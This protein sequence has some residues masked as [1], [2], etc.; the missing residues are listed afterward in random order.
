MSTTGKEYRLAIRIAGIIDK[1]FTT[2]LATAKST[3]SSFAATVSAMDKDFTKLDRGYN[4]IMSA[5]RTCF[6]AIGTAATVAAAAVGTVTVAAIK[7]GSEF[8]AQM[9]TVQAISGASN[10]E[11]EL[12]TQ[13]ARELGQSSVF[14]AT[15][16]GNAMEYMGMAGWKTEQILTGI[17]GVLNL[18]AASGEDFGMVSDIVT[19]DLTAFNMTAD[20]TARMV[21]VMAQAAMNSNT[22]VAKMGDTFKYA[23]SVA[24]AMGYTI[25]DIA[26]ATGLMA[27]SGVKSGMAGTALRNII[28][29]MAKPTK[30]SKE[31]MD[32]LGLSLTDSAGNM[33]SFYDIMVK[34]RK[35]MSGMT[36]T[37][38]AYYGAELG[39]MR[40]MTG[41]L[42]IANAT[43][44]EFQ[45]LTEA[46]Y[47][48][49]GAAERMAEIRL[50]NLSGDVQIMK[51]AFADAGMEIYYQFNDKLRGAVQ[52]VTELTN[53]AKEGIPKM[54]RTVGTEFPTL[55]R[56]FNK[57]AKP[58]FGGIVDA[59]KWLIKNGNGIVS[60]FVGIGTALAAYKIASTTVHVLHSLMSLASLNPATMAVLGLVAAIGALAGAYAAYKQHERDLID[61]SLADHFGNVALSMEELRQVAEFL[62]SSNSLTGAKK[63]LEEFGKLDGFIEE[64]NEAVSEIDKMNW[65]VSIGMKLSEDEN[66]AYKQAISDYVSEAQEYALQSQYA[67]S[68]NLQLAFGDGDGQ[69]V[70]DK[71]NEFY[72]ERYDTLA[73][74]GKQLNSAVTDAFNDGLLEID[75]ADKIASI[76]RQMAEV[77]RSLATGELDAKL[78][79]LAM[80]NAGG[81]ALS[82]EAFQNLQEGLNNYVA[83]AEKIYGESYTKNLAALNATREGGALTGDEYQ[84]ALDELKA[85]YL[86]DVGA[87]QAKAAN[88]QLQTIMNQYA[89]ELGPAIQAYREKAQGILEQYAEGGEENWMAVY[90]DN[91]V[92]DLAGGDLDDTTKGAISQLL[93]AAKPSMEQLQEIRKGYEELGQEIPEAI[94]DG[95][96]TWNLLDA[97]VNYKQ[98]G[99]FGGI[100]A[101]DSAGAVLGSEIAN[102]GLYDEFYKS[103]IENAPDALPENIADGISNAAAALAASK[104]TEAAEASVRPAVEGMYAW[105]QDAINEYYAK[106]FEATASV[107]VTLNPTLKAG[108]STFGNLTLPGWTASGNLNGIKHNAMGGIVQNETLSWLAENGPEAVIP[109][110]GSRRAMSLWER[111]GQ[112]L[113]MDSSLDGLD[114]DGGSSY[115]IEYS[116]TLKFYGAAPSKDDLT[117]A[118][119]V[120]QDEFDSMME[121]YLKT[122]SRVS[123]G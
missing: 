29:R 122:H 30:E 69:D 15:E 62:V 88:F 63:A 28:T 5:G 26:I 77:Q 98:H 59:G 118:L 93:E 89:D 22:N 70:T 123:F 121:R 42:A 25:E 92:M 49:E 51:D 12:L 119:R 56:K 55:Q 85:Q 66:E 86:N 114:L 40:G 110:D 111:A 81:G 67:V 82:P 24:G 3:T 50:D 112:L 20:E 16:V 113:G 60:V 102:S 105:S 117:D 34:M 18:A 13:K 47:N 108:A 68:V 46:I 38:K 61:Q 53:N 9:S 37:Q 43:D 44:E 74:L 99:I 107:S 8:E 79:L 96:A 103:I 14:S 78:S 32:A 45:T 84:K 120:S 1:S 101:F 115:T 35:S 57:F 6:Q 80:Q 31:A 97:M 83:E 36:E 104:V 87:A 10:E 65:K 64:M 52:W 100:D 7:V 75:E 17:D 76:Q 106:G 71:V 41:L 4:K 11:M 109:L 72:Q 19:D 73:A 23:G 48:S 116:P 58:V 90:W 21:D 39:G 95:I 54:I 91:M 27:S 94:A 2:S 33:N